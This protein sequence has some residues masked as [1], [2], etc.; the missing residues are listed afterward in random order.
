MNGKHDHTTAVYSPVWKNWG[1][2]VDESGRQK[3]FTLNMTL[4]DCLKRMG[5]MKLTESG[6]QEPFTL[7]MTLQDGLKRMGEKQLTN[8]EGRSRLHYI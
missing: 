8:Q 5:K 3:P 4:Q 7:H 6:R 2:K 1:K